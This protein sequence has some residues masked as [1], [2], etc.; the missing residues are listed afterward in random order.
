[1]TKQLIL[2]VQRTQFQAELDALESGVD[3]YDLDTRESMLDAWVEF[4]QE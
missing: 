2:N 4:T 3:C 1:M